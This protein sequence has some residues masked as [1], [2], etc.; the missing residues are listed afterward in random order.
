MTANRP[1]A[2]TK[3]SRREALRRLGAAGVATTAAFAAPG[4]AGASSA[5]AARDQDA[6]IE[7]FFA[8]LNSGQ[9][10]ELDAFVAPDHVFHMCGQDEPVVG[11]AALKALLAQARVLEAS[12]PY[13]LETVVANGEQVAAR[14]TRQGTSLDRKTLEP[15]AGTTTV[16]GQFIC[17][18]RDGLVA[19]TWNVSFA[20]NSD[21]ESEEG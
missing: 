11:R 17:R 12:V 2:P 1:T 9:F 20:R 13:R 19:E 7:R 18:F 21:D 14:W 5:S 8:V 10:D 6:L 15:T 16:E 3:R 4:L